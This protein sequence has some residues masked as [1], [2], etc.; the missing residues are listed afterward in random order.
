MQ[1]PADAIQTLLSMIRK[2][3]PFN[4][5]SAISAALEIANY[6]NSVLGQNTTDALP[7]SATPDFDLEQ[8]LQ[9]TLDQ[10]SEIGR[11]HV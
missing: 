1:F 8:A 10:H 9:N 6:I 3:T 2:Q 4:L 11:A 5:T 7:L